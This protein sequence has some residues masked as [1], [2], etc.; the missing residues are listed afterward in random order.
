MAT[1]LFL[2]TD[3]LATAAAAGSLSEANSHLSPPVDW[4]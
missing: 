2:P 1:I 3:L 4:C